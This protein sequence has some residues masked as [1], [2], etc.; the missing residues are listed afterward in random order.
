MQRINWATSIEVTLFEVLF[1]VRDA[2]ETKLA[3]GAPKAIP[4]PVRPAWDGVDRARFRA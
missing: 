3:A 4:F 2:L 1:M